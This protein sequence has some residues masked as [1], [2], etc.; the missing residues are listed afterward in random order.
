[1]VSIFFLLLSFFFSFFLAR[2]THTCLGENSLLLSIHL[3]VVCFSF[4]IY[5]C[6]L[7]ITH[8][9]NIK[10][11]IYI[12]LFLEYNIKSLKC[13]EKVLKMNS[14]FG[15][16]LADAS[17]MN[18]SRYWLADHFSGD[19]FVLTGIY[20]Q[21]Y[22]CNSF[23][24][25]ICLTFFFFSGRTLT[26]YENLAAIQKASNKTINV[27]RLYQGCGHVVYKGSFYFHNAGTNNLKKYVP[28]FT[29]MIL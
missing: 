14:T 27:R 4:F 10:I 3:S 28:H 18:D 15:A 13:S 6:F 20:R 24:L 16:W 8:L 7:L 26:E 21:I 5:L 2:E 22:R 23:C 9:H 1:M 25:F 19:L 11:Y 12:F 17:R 29:L